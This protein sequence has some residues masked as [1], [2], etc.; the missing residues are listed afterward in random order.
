MNPKEALRLDNQLCFTIYACSRAMT[1]LYR[2]WFDKLGLTYPQ[3]LVLLILWEEDGVTVKDIG[4]R[5]FLDSGTL[6]PLLKRMEAAKLIKRNRSIEDERRVHIFLT[7]SGQAMQEQ[8][9]SI[10]VE[11]M[12]ERGLSPEEFTGLL[13]D[14]KQLLGKLH[15]ALDK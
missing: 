6:T 13:A 15:H 5:L 3:Y 1:N 2:P 9:C 10:P 7:E 11:M 8:A 12:R 4:E 14:F